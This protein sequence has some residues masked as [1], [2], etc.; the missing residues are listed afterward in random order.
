LAQLQQLKIS[1]SIANASEIPSVNKSTVWMTWQYLKTDIYRP[2]SP[3]VLGHG[4]N[5]LLSFG[6]ISPFY[7]YGYLI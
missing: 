7:R 2:S 1:L 4:K 6:D 5:D 3:C